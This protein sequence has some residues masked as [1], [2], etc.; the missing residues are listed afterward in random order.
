MKM[1]NL[2]NFNTHESFSHGLVTSKIWLCEQLEKALGDRESATINILG[3]W[4]NLLAFMLVVRKPTYYKELHGYDIDPKSIAV[5][6]KICDAWLFETTKIYNHVA[7]ANSIPFV[8]N[9]HAF[10]NCSVDQFIS[11]E[12]FDN[13]PIGSLVC[14]QSS[15]MPIENDKWEITQSVGSLTELEEKYKMSKVLYKGD[16][17]IDYGTWGY[18]RFML[19]GIK[20]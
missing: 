19:I 3:C 16:F 20:K 7:D 8:D 11:N 2:D 10:I 13:I 6:N 15:D 12:W 18:T 5:A 17:Y 4:D 9:T 14:I 1:T